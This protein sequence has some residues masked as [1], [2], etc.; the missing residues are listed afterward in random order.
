MNKFQDFHGVQAEWCQ[1][2]SFRQYYELRA[3]E[4]IFATL[5]YPSA[6][7]RNAIAQTSDDHWAFLH[8]G[9]LNPRIVA[10]QS[11]SNEAFAVYQPC[12][13]GGGELE[14][15]SGPVLRWEAAN[16][17]GAD[18]LFLDPNGIE[19]LRFE[20]GI[21]NETWRDIFKT[22]RTLWLPHMGAFRP[23]L[24]FLACMGMVLLDHNL[25]RIAAT[26]AQTTTATAS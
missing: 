4:L 15:H 1:P 19:L 3:G 11:G 10:R 5:H 21:V 7:S 17:Q 18:W 20:D 8:A 16:S 9:F 26:S 22:Q 13:A 12:M 14:F 25:V 2:S 24:P 6:L 23:W